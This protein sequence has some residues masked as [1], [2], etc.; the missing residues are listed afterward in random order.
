LVWHLPDFSANA[1]VDSSNRN[2]KVTTSESGVEGV[3]LNAQCT[4]KGHTDTVEDVAF[5]PTDSNILCSVSDDTRLLFWDSRCDHGKPVNA[6]KASEVDV[7]VVDWNALNTNLIATGGKDKIVKVWDW[8]KIG[9]FSSP[10]KGGKKQQEGETASEKDMVIMSHSHEGEILRASWSPHDENVF[11]SAS[12]DGCLNV[13]DLSRK[14]GTNSSDEE[15]T[16]TANDNDK[17]NTDGATA[18]AENDS[19]EGDDGNT[20]KPKKSRFGEAPPDEL[21]FTHS[22]H[23]NP[24]T[25]FQWNPHDPWTVVSSGSGANVASTCQFWRISDLI[26]R[27]KEEVMQELEKHS[28]YICGR[29]AKPAESDDD[30]EDTGDDTSDAGDDPT[31]TKEEDFVKR[32]EQNMTRNPSYET[33]QEEAFEAMDL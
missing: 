31:N 11:A 24:I 26:T 30:T 29:A 28:A 6:V 21:L 16:T 7:H 13:W 9:E 27:P 2:G 5:H 32:E 20:N 4:F 14:K 3:R 25:D 8:R 18:G 15:A 12:D 1:A 19:G 22:G 23:R 10:R 17:P 33:A